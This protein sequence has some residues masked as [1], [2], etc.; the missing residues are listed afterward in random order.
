MSAPAP[1][2]T[3]VLRLSADLVDSSYSKPR[4]GTLSYL[5]RKTLSGGG[6][7]RLVL[8]R[9]K[10]ST[11]PTDQAHQIL[12]PEDSTTAGPQ[13]PPGEQALRQLLESR[14]RPARQSILN[15]PSD[16]AKEAPSQAVSTWAM[17]R[18]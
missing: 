4:S 12:G 8:P 18:G 3:I 10:A 11:D 2:P 14:L 5:L 7:C 17:W 13:A 9:G 16:N 15:H 1:G 6:E